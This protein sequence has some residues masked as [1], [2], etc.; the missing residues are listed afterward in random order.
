MAA[1]RQYS[2]VQKAEALAAL[3]ANAGNVKRTARELGIPEG[4]VTDWKRGKGVFLG[5]DLPAEKEDDLA[6]L[7]EDT[8]KKLLKVAGVKA[9]EAGARDAMVASGIAIDKARLLRDQPT[10]I[11]GVTVLQDIPTEH[12]GEMVR[13]AL[14]KAPEAKEAPDKKPESTAVVLMPGGTQ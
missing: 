11:Q 14:D 10:Q 1:R 6:Q 8:A 4:T 13:E 9:K 5:V 12:L 3:K 7:Y 2:D